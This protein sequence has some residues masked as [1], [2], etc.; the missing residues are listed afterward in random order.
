MRTTEPETFRTGDVV[1]LRDAVLGRKA[2]TAGKRAVVVGG[3][4]C[5]QAV[6]APASCA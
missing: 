1:E 2:L 5:A 6:T 4:S 3:A